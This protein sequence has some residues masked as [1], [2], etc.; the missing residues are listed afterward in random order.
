MTPLERISGTCG[1][2]GNLCEL[3]LKT[4]GPLALGNAETSRS[5]GS[6][7]VLEPMEPEPPGP[8]GLLEVL[9]H[10]NLKA[11]RGVSDQDKHQ[12]HQPGPTPK[13]TDTEEAQ[14]LQEI[15][16]G[17]QPGPTYNEPKL[18]FQ[19]TQEGIKKG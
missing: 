11:P 19:G 18:E 5:S 15:Q 16:G 14:E 3:W 7:D 12:G 8:L 2:S 9:D 1:T 10:L 13:G 4:L 17:H 6:S